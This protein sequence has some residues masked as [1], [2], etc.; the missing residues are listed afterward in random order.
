L[1]RV[2]QNTATRF[3]KESG[4]SSTEYIP[5]RYEKWRPYVFDGVTRIYLDP[6]EPM[7]QMIRSLNEQLHGIPPCSCPR[8][9]TESESGEPR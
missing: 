6:T 1:H 9:S 8:C 3:H 4:V 7:R 5:C 2:V